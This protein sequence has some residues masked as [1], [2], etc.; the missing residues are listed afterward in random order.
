MYKEEWRDRVMNREAELLAERWI[1]DHL[2]LFNYAVSIG[3]TEWQQ[4]IIA[5]LNNKSSM[6]QKEIHATMMQQL[7]S[8]YDLIN[9]KMLELFTKMRETTSSV[10]ESSIKELIWK[11]KLQRIDLARRIQTNCG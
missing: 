3:D 7:W 2:D 10:E 11:L 6:I 4:E 1:D 9:D 8:K 5:I